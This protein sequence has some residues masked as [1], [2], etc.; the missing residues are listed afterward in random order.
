[1]ENLLFW[2]F[3]L[4]DLNV[5]LSCVYDLRLFFFTQARTWIKEKNYPKKCSLLIKCFVSLSFTHFFFTLVSQIKIMIIWKNTWNLFFFRKMFYFS[6]FHRCKKKNKNIKMWQTL[7]EIFFL[8][9][10]CFTSSLFFF[11]IQVHSWFYFLLIF[12]NPV[13]HMK[14]HFLIKFLY[15][16][17]FTDAK[18]FFKK[19]RKN[20]PVNTFCTEED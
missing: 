15:S 7:Q 17:S 12:F 6:Q 10:F 3:S 19:R 16:S 11:S 14:K 9:K 20:C 1:M 18:T 5:F 4:S 2:W 8:S 13:S